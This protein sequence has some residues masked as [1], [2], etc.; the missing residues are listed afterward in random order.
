MEFERTGWEP[1]KGKD[2]ME[3]NEEG[4]SPLVIMVVLVLAV[5]FAGSC[6]GLA[7]GA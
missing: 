1:T 6:F 2:D 7:L 3:G 5:F 4:F